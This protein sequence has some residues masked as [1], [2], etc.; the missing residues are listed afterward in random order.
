[1][2]L[3]QVFKIIKKHFDNPK[4]SN[5]QGITIT[6][7]LIGGKISFGFDNP[8]DLSFNYAILVDHFWEHCDMVLK[9]LG[10]PIRHTTAYFIW[11]HDNMGNLLYLNP[12]DRDELEKRYQSVNHIEIKIDKDIT[13]IGDLDLIFHDTPRLTQGDEGLDISAKF[14]MYNIRNGEGS[15]QFSLDSNLGFIRNWYHDD[16]NNYDE[17]SYRTLS[18]VVSF[19]ESNPLLYDNSWMYITSFVTVESLDEDNKA[20]IF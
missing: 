8:N 7:E 11:Y 3:E 5:C 19:I 9:F 2:K 1:M 18:P 4:V 17:I 12:S 13:V 16:Y 20:I 6:P 10:N 15:R 14:F